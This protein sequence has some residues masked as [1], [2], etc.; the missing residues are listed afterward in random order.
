M[1]R[2][3]ATKNKNYVL[4]LQQKLYVWKCHCNAIP[5]FTEPAVS[6]EETQMVVQES[7]T[8]PIFGHF[9]FRR[10]GTDLRNNTVVRFVVDIL[11]CLVLVVL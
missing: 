4:N 11:N 6:F 2:V 7:S 1:T 9:R 8:N 5:V 10:T 3:T